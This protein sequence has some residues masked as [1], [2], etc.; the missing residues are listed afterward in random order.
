MHFIGSEGSFP[1]FKGPATCSY[2]KPDQSSPRSPLYFVKTHFNIILP[3]TPRSQSDLFFLRFPYQTPICGPPFPHKFYQPGPFLYS[4]IIFVEEHGSWSTDYAVSSSPVSSSLL[5][6]NIFL[7]SL[8]CS[9]FSPNSSLSMRDQMLHPYKTAG[10]I[11]VLYIFV[12][13]FFDSKLAERWF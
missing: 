3:S 7:S 8:F 10:K 2:P 12:F 13:R 4:R 1:P 5:G 11:I 6:Q 9:T